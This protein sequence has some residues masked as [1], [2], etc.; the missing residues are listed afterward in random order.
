MAEKTTPQQQ[1][2]VDDAVIE[3][4]DLESVA[5]GI[6]EGGCIPQF[7]IGKTS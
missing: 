3:D 5:G 2:P 6:I 1:N 4:T 7:P